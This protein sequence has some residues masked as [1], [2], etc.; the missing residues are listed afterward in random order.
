MLKSQ[1][2]SVT[3]KIIQKQN[4][5]R[6]LLCTQPL[7]PLPT[8]APHTVPLLC[9]LLPCGLTAVGFWARQ[10]FLAT[11]LPCL[12]LSWAEGP[13][14]FCSRRASL[15]GGGLGSTM[16]SLPSGF[17]APLHSTSICGLTLIQRHRH[18]KIK[19][20]ARCPDKKLLHYLDHES[21]V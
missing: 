3:K 15:A 14:P 13:A 20:C 7:N 8:S 2:V 5:T 16:G 18:F 1:S 21:V 11:G 17:L 12:L 6:L 4:P 10:G 9:Q 19:D